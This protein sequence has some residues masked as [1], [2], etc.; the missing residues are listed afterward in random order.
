MC[1][2]TQSAP[3][4]PCRKAN[5][6]PP[7]PMNYPIQCIE[8]QRQAAG[9]RSIP[10]LK[11]SH[12]QLAGRFVVRWVHLPAQTLGGMTRQPGLLEEGTCMPAGFPIGPGDAVTGGA[13]AHAGTD[14]QACKWVPCH[15]DMHSAC[16][17]II[18]SVI[19]F[20]TQLHIT[21]WSS[22]MDFAVLTRNISGGEA[23]QASS[24]GRPGSGACAVG[25]T[26]AVKLLVSPLQATQHRR[27]EGWRQRGA[28]G[29]K[30]GQLRG[31]GARQLAGI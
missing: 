14:P 22:T 9:T 8:L 12:A 6:A 3:N 25:C 29:H 19:K 28:L 20:A 26:R 7:L 4:S 16:G 17:H 27:P 31:D 10:H 24:A 18:F 11:Q 5:C 23:A 15:A 30:V 2:Y 13:R 21:S 1:F